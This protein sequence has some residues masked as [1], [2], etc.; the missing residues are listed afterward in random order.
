MAEVLEVVVA[1]AAAEECGVPE[2][3]EVQGDRE[4]KAVLTANATGVPTE[5]H[6]GD[7][8]VQN[9]PR[10]SSTPLH[11]AP[12]RSDTAGVTRD[13]RSGERAYQVVK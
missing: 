6:K 8:N 11:P 3:T 10:V 9:V 4:V 7:P 13:T 12:T 1:Q 5:R 2:G